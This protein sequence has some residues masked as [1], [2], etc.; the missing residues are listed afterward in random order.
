MAAG[1]PLSPYVGELIHPLTRDAHLLKSGL[2]PLIPLIMQQKSQNTSS[3]LISLY[4][5]WH[6][7]LF[8]YGNLLPCKKCSHPH[9]ST[10]WIY[11]VRYVARPQG[12]ALRS[13]TNSNKRGPR[14]RTA[15]VP[16]SSFS[17]ILIH[18]QTFSFMSPQLRPQISWS[19]DTLAVQ[20]PDLQ[21]QQQMK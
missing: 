5:A 14:P 11:P 9:A 19:W 4:E 16:S 1:N 10:R 17:V 18:S 21:I 3:G 12:G 8:L 13:P 7:P 6:F 20:V 15:V 2:I